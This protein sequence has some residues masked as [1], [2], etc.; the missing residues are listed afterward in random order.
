MKI[1]ICLNGKGNEI[2]IWCSFSIGF[3]LFLNNHRCYMCC[4]RRCS[5]HHICVSRINNDNVH[6]SS[7]TIYGDKNIH[8]SSN[9]AK[10]MVGDLLLN[11]CSTFQSNN[12]N[13]V[14]K[15]F[16]GCCMFILAWALK[17]MGT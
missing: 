12:C 17:Q 2:I 15:C 3:C 11:M 5:L 14:T 1:T 6:Q 10:E 4:H 16:M 8:S 7:K 9:V 13:S